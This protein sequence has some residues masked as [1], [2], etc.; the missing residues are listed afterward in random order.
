MPQLD[1]SWFFFL[2]RDYGLLRPR[3][4]LCILKNALLDF[5]KPDSLGF[6][7]H[8]TVNPQLRLISR[9]F[10][11]LISRLWYL[12]SKTSFPGLSFIFFSPFLALRSFNSNLPI[13]EAGGDV[14]SYTTIVSR[15]Y[16]SKAFVLSYCMPRFYPLY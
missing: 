8:W 6:L 14:R 1:T 7:R 13:F 5:Y 10:T 9:T 3:E 12:I 11:Q 15:M 16:S 2:E 4:K